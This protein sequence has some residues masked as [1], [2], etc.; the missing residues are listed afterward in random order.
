MAL[1][2]VR[3][4]NGL[5]PGFRPSDRQVRRERNAAAL[6]YAARVMKS[7]RCDVCDSVVFFENILCLHCGHALGFLPDVLD[8]SALE[9][10]ASG[11]WRALAR[12]AENRAYRLCANGRKHGLC[13][14]MVPADDPDPLCAACRLNEV[15]PDLRVRGNLLRWRR[16]ETAKRRLLYTV[17]KLGLGMEG[18]PAEARPPLRFQFLGD[19]PG[20][21]TIM[22]GHEE[23]VITLNI[24]EADDEVREQRRV[25]FNEPLRTLVG[26]FRHEAAHY[27]WLLLIVDSAWLP[28]FRELFGD[29]TTHY[30]TELAKYHRNG[31]ATDWAVR[32]VS[33]YA[34]AHPWEDW[35][36]TTA[37]YFHIVDSVETAAEYGISFRSDE[38]SS[39]SRAVPERHFADGSDCDD[40]L[41]TWMPLASVLNSFNR[42]MGLPDLY[43]FVLSDAAVQ[44][45]RFVHEVL[46]AAGQPGSAVRVREA[47]SA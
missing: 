10:E 43:P 20:R 39:N 37:H 6:H 44:K 19:A 31:P 13:N 22:T 42:G 46:R 8:L 47:T 29:E 28:R 5:P 32:G 35:A 27:Y 38:A 2:P 14:W 23:G 40:L 12:A 11:R 36:E 34:S 16:I 1:G 25:Q 30:R 41:R 21:P 18:I 15:V 4:G 7:F 17:L 24:A 45:L 26:H 9:P 3:N 33:A